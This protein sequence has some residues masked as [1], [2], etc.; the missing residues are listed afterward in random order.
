MSMSALG[1]L[2]LRTVVAATLVQH[3]PVWT[4]VKLKRIKPNEAYTVAEIPPKKTVKGF[5][6]QRTVI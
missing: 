5:F 3:I 1:I 2:A 6:Q 4:F